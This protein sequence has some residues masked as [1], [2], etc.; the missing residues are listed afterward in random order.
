MKQWLLL[1]LALGSQQTLQYFTDKKIA[2]SLLCSTGFRH[3]R[4]PE[5][6]IVKYPKDQLFGAN[7]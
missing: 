3:Q 1:P 5:V 2:H 7:S 6:L 4:L